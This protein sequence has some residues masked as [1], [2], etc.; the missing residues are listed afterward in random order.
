MGDFLKSLVA[1]IVAFAIFTFPATWLF[2]LFAGNVGWNWGYV[3]VLPLG[4]L[5]SVLLGGVTSRTW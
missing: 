1:M 4:I 2:M 5:I 3:E